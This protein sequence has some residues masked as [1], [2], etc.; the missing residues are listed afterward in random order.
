MAWKTD[1]HYL[2]L[3]HAVTRVE[4][5]PLAH[6]YVFIHWVV[7]K[8]MLIL[9]AVLQ[10]LWAKGM[11]IDIYRSNI[12]YSHKWVRKIMPKLIIVRICH[13]FN[14]FWYVSRLHCVASLDSIKLVRIGKLILPISDSDVFLPFQTCLADPLGR[15]YQGKHYPDTTWSSYSPAPLWASSARSHLQRPPKNKD[16]KSHLLCVFAYVNALM[17]SELHIHTTVITTFH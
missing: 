14:F 3:T 7:V 12:A 15:E 1:V 11:S 16:R 9:A 13:T 5:D 4:D 6:H 10:L 8:T 2:V 17:H